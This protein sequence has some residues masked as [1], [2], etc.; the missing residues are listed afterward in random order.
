MTSNS[1][2]CSRCRVA[3]CA[4]CRAIA[5]EYEDLLRNWQAQ[6]AR[7][8]CEIAALQENLTLARAQAAHWETVAKLGLPE[9]I[10]KWMDSIVTLQ[11]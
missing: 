7:Q 6:H 11:E 3:M 2:L 9:V 8:A 10:S 1:H 5:E 4:D